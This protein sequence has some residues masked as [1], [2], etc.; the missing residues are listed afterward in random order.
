MKY[1][2]A[3]IFFEENLTL[4]FNSIE[5]GEFLEI[6][7]FLTSEVLVRLEIFEGTRIYHVY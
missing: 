4:G 6:L 3:E 5:S 2:R 7:K 1:I